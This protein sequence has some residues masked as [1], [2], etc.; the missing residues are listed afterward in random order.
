MKTLIC[1]ILIL[2]SI[3]LG[4]P[5]IISDSAPDCTT[6]WYE[7][8]GDTTQYPTE[9]D[10]SIKHDVVNQAVG[11]T[12]Y[13]MRYCAVWTADAGEAVAECS[14]W[15]PPFRVTRPEK[16]GTPGGQKLVP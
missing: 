2:P 4:A 11:T 5:F 8:D 10:G 3:A 6:C 13:K 7:V 9:P 14:D 12:I 15:T 1:L 16:P